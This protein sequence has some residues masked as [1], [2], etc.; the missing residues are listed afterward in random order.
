MS[1]APSSTRPT[2][3]PPFV[4][5]LP[6]HGD[7]TAL[8]GPDGAWT[9]RDLAQRV[10][11]CADRMVGQ[12]RLVLLVGA[13]TADA[14][15]AYLAALW[16]GHVVLLCPR[17]AAPE[18]IAQYDPDIVVGDLGGPWRVQVHREESRHQLHE[19]LAL[20]L[21]TSGSTGSA[22]LV[23][24]S[25]QNLQ[26]NAESIAEYLRITA[27]DRA[28]TTLPMYYCYGLSVIH[29]YL[30]RGAS[31]VLTEHSVADAEFWHL[32][33]EQQVTSF[34]GVPHTFD[35]LDRVGFDNL[36]LP[37]LRYITQ[38]GG[39]L[40]PERVRHYATLG[41]RHGW[42]FFVMYG[43][44]EATA[45]MAY[46]P[47]ALAA[48]HPDCI[49][50]PIPGGSLRLDPVPEVDDPQAGELVYA[51]PNVMLGYAQQP[52]DLALGREVDELRTGDIARRNPAGLFQ[53]VGR[54]S[55]FLKLFGLRIDLQQIEDLLAT[56]SGLT[57]YCTGDDTELVIGVIDDDLL[58]PTP[59]QIR[60]SVALACG[61]PEWII[62]PVVVDDVPRLDNG[63]VDYPALRALART[64]PA[65][66]EATD[67][68]GARRD[69]S[70]DAGRADQQGQVGTESE[71]AAIYAAV[72]G[73]SDV[74]PESSF[75]SLGGDSLSY[76]EASVRLE[77]A[78]GSLPSNW[79]T[80]SVRELEART[81]RRRVLGTLDMSVAIRAIAI[82]IICG[83]HTGVF[84]LPGTAL[85]LL[86]VVGFN[87]GRLQVVDT[88]RASRV[89]RTAASIARIAIPT[90]VW[91]AIGWAV[92]GTYGWTN[93][94]FASLF[95]SGGG[96][97]FLWFVDVV[98]F[99]LLAMVALLATPWG[100]RLTRRYPFGFPLA[101]VGVG[102]VLR[103]DL[104]PFV[105]L[106]NH[107]LDSPL[108]MIVAFW[109]FAVG[110][111]LAKSTR[112][113]QRLL[114]TAVVLA[115]VP[116][117]S[118]EVRRDV[119]T[120]VT[121]LLL[122]WVPALPSIRPVSWLLATIASASLYI[123]IMHFAIMPW[124]HQALHALSLRGNP[125]YAGLITSIIAGVLYCKLCTAAEQWLRRAVRN[126]R[127]RA[128][129]RHPDGPGTAPRTAV[130]EPEQ[131]L[132]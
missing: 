91:C 39:R 132:L 75:A 11:E 14:L 22:K 1:S 106:S 29:S 123:Y 17:G 92:D 36:H 40:A 59:E 86:A 99:T 87:F 73:R 50:V 121:V 34:A 117:F 62:R 101:L 57:A 95:I 52:A 35:L 69:P 42:E 8:I 33:R 94:I 27:A 104:I 24:L 60:R 98:V 23:R 82:V 131:S 48:E 102:L 84:N 41:Q 100:D 89:T 31:L 76:V 5:D 107:R 81:R 37:R 85:A 56:G 38:A 63:K 53:I 96:N 97:W 28:A 105:D 10:Q 4:A 13:N 112:V 18:L 124:T 109:L 15:V 44:T 129:D 55:R 83:T 113:W 119:T 79:P 130:A 71:V 12:P 61:L 70:G 72:L 127:A 68:T 110:W 108:I 3:V 66:R 114:L 32:M 78:L 19:D 6:R 49:G 21:S 9:Y 116:G 120:T 74:T 125:Y 45:R 67:G 118:G 115:A 46:L 93:L 128:T 126:R 47:P 2:A 65:P 103:Y 88:P 26:A 90:I 25:R 16:A 77:Q 20:L 51:G 7:A 64:V 30:Y 111:A 122:I 43:Q 58:R 54:R 80:L